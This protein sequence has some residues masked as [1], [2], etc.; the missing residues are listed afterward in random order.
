MRGN[1][2]YGAD[3]RTTKEVQA[4]LERDPLY[5]FPNV[6]V[7]TYRGEVQLGGYVNHPSQREQAVKDASA[8]PGVLQVQDNM[9]INTNPPVTPVE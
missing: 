8:V 1:T 6:S 3:K 7:V 5:K 9:M 4:A 2:Q